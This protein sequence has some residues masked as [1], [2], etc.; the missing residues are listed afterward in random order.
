MFHNGNAPT[1]PFSSAASSVKHP[2]SSSVRSSCFS[3]ALGNGASDDF[4]SP[5]PQVDEEDVACSEKRNRIASP[6]DHSGDL[7]VEVDSFF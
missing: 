7:G 3:C 1:L 6:P 4:F 2:Y 5:H